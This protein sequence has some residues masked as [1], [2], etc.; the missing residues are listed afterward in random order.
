MAGPRPPPLPGP[1]GLG[2]RRFPGGFVHPKALREALLRAFRDLGGTYLR[3]EVEGIEGE[4]PLAGR[5]P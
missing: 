2:A 5:G 1:G 4:G 3:A